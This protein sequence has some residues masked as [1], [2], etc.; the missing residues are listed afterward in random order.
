MATATA[1]RSQILK[2][3]QTLTRVL[4]AA[5]PRLER[6]RTDPAQILAGAGFTP[7]PWQAG[8]LRSRARRVQLLCHR[9]AGKS[10]TAA[11]LAL[12]AALLEP[13][14]LV[15]LLSPT[16]RQS[17]ELFR[18]KVLRLWQGLGSPCK[19]RSPTQLTLELR[20]GSRIVSLPENEEG[21]RGFSGVRLLVVDE[22]SRVSDALYKAVRPMLAVSGGKLVALSTPFGKRGWFYDTWHGSSP[23]QRVRVTAE[24]CPRITAEFLAEERLELGERWFKQEYGCD[25]LEVTGSVFAAEDIEA[26]FHDG[27]SPLFALPAGTSREAAASGIRSGPSDIPPL[28][29]EGQAC[30]W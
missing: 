22:A 13:P 6:L 24:Q 23:W 20:N 3:R 27:I 8:V 14:A 4:P 5:D 28:F 18:D 2:L 15:L 25:F 29:E 10:L 11:A 9:Q 30:P 17:G 1:L 21:I 7:D 12:R 26:A 16:L 19:A